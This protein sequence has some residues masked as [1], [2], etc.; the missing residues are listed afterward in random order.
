IDE[1]ERAKW[2]AEVKFLKAYYHFFLMQLYGPIVLVK[3]NLPLSASPEETKVYREPVDE[4]VDYIVELLDE[5]IADLP[6]TI[7]DPTTEQGRISQV[8]ALGIKARVLAW[9]ASPIFN[10]NQ[11]HAGWID[12]R[13]KQVISSTYDPTKWERAATAIKEAIDLAHSLGFR[14][15]EFNKFT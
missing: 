5:A 15:Y 7:Q 14:L 8:I 1:V 9:A 12:N 13:G 11:D 10:G 2:M 6:P 3:E 4:C